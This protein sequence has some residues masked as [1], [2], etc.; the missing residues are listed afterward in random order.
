MKLTSF[1]SIFGG[2]KAQNLKYSATNGG[3][4]GAKMVEKGIY[5]RSERAQFWW[6]N[7]NLHTSEDRLPA[8]PY[9]LSD[10]RRCGVLF[11]PSVPP[12]ARSV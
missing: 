7:A 4:Q 10:V 8:S 5:G 11:G 6:K 3:K 12:Q 2:N 1:V 9:R